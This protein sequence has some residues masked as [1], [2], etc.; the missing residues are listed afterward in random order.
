MTH[1]PDW[2][3]FPKGVQETLAKMNQYADELTRATF[4]LQ[5]EV[6]KQLKQGRA[7]NLQLEEKSANTLEILSNWLADEA[8]S[9]WQ[10]TRHYQPGIPEPACTPFYIREPHYIHAGGQ[11]ASMLFFSEEHGCRI[12]SETTPCY[13]HRACTSKADQR[14][15]ED[16]VRKAEKICKAERRQQPL[17]AGEILPLLIEGCLPLDYHRETKILRVP[18]S[19][20]FQSHDE[21]AARSSRAARHLIVQNGRIPMPEGEHQLPHPAATLRLAGRGRS[22]S[23]VEE[24][25]RRLLE[26]IL[27]HLPAAEFDALKNTLPDPNQAE[28]QLA[29]NAAHGALEKSRAAAKILLKDL[30]PQILKVIRRMGPKQNTLK[31]AMLA[32]AGNDILEFMRTRP[33]AACRIAEARGGNFQDAVFTLRKDKSA[34]EDWN[35][36]LTPKAMETGFQIRNLVETRTEENEWQWQ[37]EE[38]QEN[39]K[40]R[41]CTGLRA[42]KSACESAFAHRLQNDPDGLLQLAFEIGQ[43]TLHADRDSW[44]A[45][46]DEQR[47]PVYRAA[48]EKNPAIPCGSLASRAAHIHALAACLMRNRNQTARPEPWRRITAHELGNCTRLFT[49]NLLAPAIQP[50]HINALFATPGDEAPDWQ[51]RSNARQKLG[52]ILLD[53]WLHQHP[54]SW[55]EL[56]DW[57]LQWKTTEEAR[58]H[59]LGIE[60]PGGPQGLHTLRTPKGKT[61][62]FVNCASEAADI[63]GNTR[64]YHEAGKASAFWYTEHPRPFD[65]WLVCKAWR[66]PKGG[67]EIRLHRTGRSGNWGK[68]PET[69]TE[70]LWKIF[71]QHDREAGRA[72]TKEEAARQILFAE[73]EG[74]HVQGAESLARNHARLPESLRQLAA[75]CLNG[76]HPLDPGSPDLDTDPEWRIRVEIGRRAETLRQKEGG[77]GRKEPFFRRTPQTENPIGGN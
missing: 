5:N 14:F 42:L 52:A 48:K 23:H 72:F 7:Q 43:G 4:T 27:R 24:T 63:T 16:V 76:H 69:E 19:A 45:D 38:S 75:L 2:P 73:G 71:R 28:A 37:L 1:W 39:R 67:A 10:V 40:Q 30:D 55:A 9:A 44:R 34:R 41:A 11:T 31:N 8:Q 33:Q 13:T 20:N 15:S 61:L 22:Q 17:A 53:L 68:V 49:R 29:G 56:E 21:A 51:S 36:K 50:A 26:R 65:H 35:P 18:G 64:N 6:R 60:P 66:I 32:S 77:G 74:S 70:A 57:V 54:C 25:A 46:S 62:R 3:G 58:I 59:G 12:K 47:K